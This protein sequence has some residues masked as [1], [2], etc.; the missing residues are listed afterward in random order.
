MCFGACLRVLKHFHKINTIVWCSSCVCLHGSCTLRASSS[1][2]R[3]S[4]SNNMH[5]TRGTFRVCTTS[6]HRVGDACLQ[7]TAAEGY[8]CANG[9]CTHKGTHVH[10]VCAHKTRK[11]AHDKGAT[12][13][14]A[15]QRADGVYSKEEALNSNGGRAAF[16]LSFVFTLFIFKAPNYVLARILTERVV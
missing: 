1:G 13:G 16:V 12:Y 2:R 10:T 11:N 3:C 8:A 5:E 14:R 4:G 7:G 6:L 15:R 9:F